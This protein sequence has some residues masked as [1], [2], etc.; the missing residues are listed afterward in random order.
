MAENIFTLKGTLFAKDKREWTGKKDPTK[1]GCTDYYILESKIVK[2]W[3][4]DGG[5]ER[6]ASVTIFPK[7]RLPYRFDP[8]SYEIGD[9]LDITFFPNGK[10]FDKKDGTGKAYITENEILTIKF[11]DIGST[12][13]RPNK[14]KVTVTSTSSADEFPKPKG[15]SLDDDEYGDLPF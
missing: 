1:K 8:D 10:E 9:P 14:G 15:A 6:S 7:F 4:D 12:G 3:N 5:K 13:Q 11:G 2:R